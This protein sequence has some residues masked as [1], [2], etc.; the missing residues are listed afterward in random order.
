MERKL[1]VKTVVTGSLLVLIPALFNAT[2]ATAAW[3]MD[4][5][6][7]LSPDYHDRP[8]GRPVAVSYADG[9]DVLCVTDAAARSLRVYTA[10]GIYTFA[11]DAL[12]ALSQPLDAAIDAEGRFVF[13]DMDAGRGRTLR[14]LDLR[15]E[16]DAFDVALP[17][18]D[19]FPEHL[20]ITR[21]GGLVTVD[22]TH[23]LLCKHDAAGA[24]LWSRTLAPEAGDRDLGL[25]RPAEAAD[26]RLYIT[27]ASLHGV[28]VQDAEGRPLD[29][30]GRFG[31][32]RGRM[33]LQVGVAVTPNGALLVLD[34]LR[35]VVLL[36]DAEHVFLGEYGSLGTHPGQFYHPSSIAAT[37]DGRVIVAQS[38]AGRVQIYRLYDSQ[39]GA[40]RAAAGEGRLADLNSASSVNFEA[41]GL[42]RSASVADASR[43]SNDG[44]APWGL[45]GF[46]SITM[47]Y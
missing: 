18:D 42:N 6:G 31:S 36:F 11:T 20:L 39:A 7:A 24:L 17:A 16:P 38:F 1:S 21:D 4:Y 30:F 25:G 40:A 13:T 43:V 3:V 35:H 41:R 46:E 15:G 9:D 27:S 23:R 45:S 8:C 32:A 33:V 14:R 12:A 19:W 10:D 2:D 28:L 5:A 29:S 37:A 47:R 34:R 44:G 26:G 22:N